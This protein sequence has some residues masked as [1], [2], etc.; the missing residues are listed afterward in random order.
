MGSWLY[1]SPLSM[2]TR[3]KLVAT[4]G[5]HV[6]ALTYDNSRANYVEYAAINSNGSLGMW[7]TQ[8]MNRTVYAGATFVVGGILVRHRH[9][10]CNVGGH[11]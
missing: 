11:Q 6:Y 10:C 5:R 8:L 9:Q 4:D 2:P 1:T 7:Q 3:N